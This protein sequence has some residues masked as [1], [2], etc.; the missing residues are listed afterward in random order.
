MSLHEHIAAVIAQ[1]QN[2]CI[3]FSE[4]MRL[5]LYTPELGY[6]CRTPLPIGKE[7]D[8]VTAP[9]I[10]PLFGRCLARQLSAILT[11]IPESNILEFGAGLGTLACEILLYLEKENALPQHYF[12]LELSAPLKEAQ[13]LQLQQRCPHLLTKVTWLNQLPHPFKGVIIANE[14]LDAM[15]VE[16]IR[17]YKDHYEQAFVTYNAS[18]FDWH[19]QK[20]SDVDLQEKADA[21][22]KTLAP[23]VLSAGYVTEVN[24]YLKP[25][26]NSVSE[27]LQSGV[28]FIIDYGFLSPHYYHP[29]RK[30][31]TL[32]CHYQHRS[33]SNPLIQ[34]GEQDITA[35]V[36]FS[37]VI[38]V[39]TQAGLKTAGYAPQAHFLLALGLLEFASLT[40][41]TIEQYQLAQQ[42]KTLTLP[43]EMGELFKVL[44]L[45]KHYEAPL[46]G[47]NH[48]YF[49]RPQF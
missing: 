48:L 30:D 42:I 43:S 36:D 45:A 18:H 6:Y 22:A 8:F 17:L 46:R 19:Y 35:H 39:A 38:E 34:V 29:D 21:I 31:G 47:F 9:E 15:P 28:I 4:F 14:V 20:I 32:M 10:S 25:W 40:H 16:I 5:A 33:H 13:R 24:P 2:R 44:A 12:I 26:I 7:G 3:P 11:T 27:C 37:A 41:S 49:A 1:T 23:E